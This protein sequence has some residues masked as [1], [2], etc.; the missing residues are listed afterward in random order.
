MR[1][2]G[3]PD[4]LCHPIQVGFRELQNRETIPLQVRG[5]GLRIQRL[6]TSKYF[7]G[8]LF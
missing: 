1:L 5:D 4:V 7:H 2:Q 3:L 6:T 8:S